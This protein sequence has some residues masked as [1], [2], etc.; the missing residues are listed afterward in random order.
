MAKV[1][2]D[3]DNWNINKQTVR[4]RTSE[5]FCCSIQK[6]AIVKI[7]GNLSNKRSSR[8]KHGGHL[9][10]E[11]SSQVAWSS[12]EWIMISGSKP[13]AK[14]RIRV[15]CTN[16]QVNASV[17]QTRQN[18]RIC[19]CL[20]FAL[21]CKSSASPEKNAKKR[22]EKEAERNENTRNKMNR[23]QNVIDIEVKWVAVNS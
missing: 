8:C 7:D 16:S 2:S 17:E 14:W 3:N 9:S 13:K 4:A 12:A 22:F 20:E 11:R 19:F 18:L 21:E 23:A 6:I 15:E 1:K 5:H 10:N